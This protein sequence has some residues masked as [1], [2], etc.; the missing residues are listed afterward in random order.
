MILWLPHTSLYRHTIR[1]NSSAKSDTSC[2]IISFQLDFNMIGFPCEPGVNGVRYIFIFDLLECPL[3]G[4]PFLPDPR[5]HDLVADPASTASAISYSG[6]LPSRSLGGARPE[7]S[8]P[9]RWP[10]IDSRAF[11]RGEI[12]FPPFCLAHLAR[13][14]VARRALGF[15]PCVNGGPAGA[16]GGSRRKNLRPFL[17]PSLLPPHPR[18][19]PRRPILRR[20]EDDAGAKDARGRG[21]PFALPLPRPSGPPVLPLCAARRR[22]LLRGRPPS[23]FRPGERDGGSASGLL[24]L[25]G[26]GRRRRP[27]G[28][29]RAARAPQPTTPIRVLSPTCSA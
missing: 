15:S 1:H 27:A 26:G 3:P 2:G 18:G 22:P 13:T 14:R 7:D 16:G 6:R 21:P 17:A 12:P 9:P 23:T 8:A 11:R 24:T 20:T 19:A 10:P 25:R 4:R 28:E 29:G 5:G